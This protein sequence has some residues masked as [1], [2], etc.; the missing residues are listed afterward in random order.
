MTE[1]TKKNIL[2]IE[3]A[4]TVGS[5]NVGGSLISLLNL[6]QGL[7]KELCRIFI[8]LYHKFDIIGEYQK[9]GCKVIIKQSDSTKSNLQTCE[10]YSRLR[11]NKSRI[12]FK[13]IPY[14]HE[15]VKNF[16]FLKKSKKIKDVMN[17]IKK[18]NID[19]VHCNNNEKKMA[20]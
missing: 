1:N 15:L 20:W 12:F 11:F 7:D 6:V 9:N 3:T 8:L 14:I 4:K 13:R 19:I 10:N 5:N 18:N 16:R 2:F 17:E